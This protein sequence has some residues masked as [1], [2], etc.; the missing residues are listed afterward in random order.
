M[1]SNL[2]SAS[3]G[4]DRRRS[5]RTQAF[6]PAELHHDE[7][8]P[9]T[10]L[11]RDVSAC[12]AQLLTPVMVSLRKQLAVLMYPSDL[13]SCVAATGTVVRV[14]EHEEGG[15]WAYVVS[16]SFDDPVPGIEP[17]AAAMAERQRALGL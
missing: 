1:Q 11:A 2:S 5:P 6:F 14:T 3:L 13:E 16:V 15:L 9:I 4:V 12:G 8:A 10:A 17:E 7:G